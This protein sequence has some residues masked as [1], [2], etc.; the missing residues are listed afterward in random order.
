M[1]A[2]TPNDATK[3]LGASK[4]LGVN[5]YLMPGDSRTPWRIFEFLGNDNCPSLLFGFLIRGKAPLSLTLSREGRE[6]T[7]TQPLWILSAL[8]MTL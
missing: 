5:L 2:V 6:D 1:A 8:R 7:S 3:V 4:D